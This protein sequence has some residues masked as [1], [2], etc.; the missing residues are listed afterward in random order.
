MFI[1]MEVYVGA[2]VEISMKTR[3]TI[4]ISE[5]VARQAREC[6][7]NLSKWIEERIV[8]EYG[9]ME[10]VEELDREIL[11]MLAAIEATRDKRDALKAVSTALDK[12]TA[13]AVKK[14]QDPDVPMIKGPATAV[15]ALAWWRDDPILASIGECGLTTAVEKRLMEAA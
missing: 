15:R 9:R 10:T 13:Q 12:F 5:S 2:E 1:Y 8:A 14:I 4:Y 6:I 3:T 11:E 7:P